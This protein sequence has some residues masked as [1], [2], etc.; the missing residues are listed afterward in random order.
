PLRGVPQG[1]AMG[2]FPEGC[3]WYQVPLSSTRVPC[4]VIFGHGFQASLQRYQ[5]LHVLKNFRLGRPIVLPPPGLLEPCSPACLPAD[6]PPS[7]SR[8]SR[9]TGRARGERGL[10]LGMGVRGAMTLLPADHQQVGPYLRT[11][12]C[13]IQ[14]GSLGMSQCPR[15]VVVPTEASPFPRS[16][17]QV[18][19]LQPDP[20]ANSLDSLVW[21]K[22][23]KSQAAMPHTSLAWA[24]VDTA[25][26]RKSL[27]E[28]P[29][30]PEEQRYPDSQSQGGP[31]RARS[32]PD[33][34][35]LPAGISWHISLRNPGSSRLSTPGSLS[36]APILNTHGLEPQSPLER[37]FLHN[38]PAY[39]AAFI[40]NSH[41]SL[42]YC[43]LPTCLLPVLWWLFQV[44]PQRRTSSP[45]SLLPLPHPLPA[46]KCWCPT[47]QDI[48]QAFTWLGT[49]LSPLFHRHLLPPELC[50]T[51]GSL[52]PSCFLS[53]AGPN[54]TSVLALV[55]QLGDICKFVALCVDTR[56]CR[57]TDGARV[58]LVTLLA[59][60]SLSQA[61]R[62]QPL[63]EVQHLLQ[64]LLE[65][66][67]DWQ[68]Q[69]ASPVPEPSCH[70]PA[71]AGAARHRATPWGAYR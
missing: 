11:G 66:I 59:F 42:P 25:S 23:E 22:R 8:P 60:L 17:A 70:D 50:P 27:D 31:R 19:C 20:L 24:H 4:S 61:L 1:P 26:P 69:G 62:C 21:E 2:P 38:S 54:A 5:Q 46:G 65:G 57:Y 12:A 32:L 55:T 63:M 48:S 35:L 7:A 14:A 49:D 9:S 28:G 40:H 68:E 13:V 34:A 64:C 36:P 44:S 16:V 33:T 45:P 30:L 6:S 18:T 71:A 67:Q 15:D 29:P 10:A 43:C 56:L 51:E 41:L 39:Q 37:F 3:R 53:Q 47:V 58:A 52:D